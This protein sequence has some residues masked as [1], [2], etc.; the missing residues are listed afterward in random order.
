MEPPTD[1]QRE[2]RWAPRRSLVY[3]GTALLIALT[4][5]VSGAHF[6]GNGRH[7]D[8]MLLY[9]GADDCAPC[10]AW[11][12]GEGADFLSSAE[13]RRIT[14]REVKSPRLDD[15]LKDENWSEDIRGLRSG[16]NRGEGVPLWL[17]VS[18]HVVVEQQFGATAWKQRVLPKIRSYLR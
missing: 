17:V 7:P 8:V 14:Y 11:R 12:N 6:A 15:V 4:T 3:L 18:D 16:I 9:V 10:R 2:H 13:S 5:I 1:I